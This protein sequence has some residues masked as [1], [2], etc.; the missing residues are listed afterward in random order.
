MSIFRCRYMIPRFNRALYIFSAVSCIKEQILGREGERFPLLSFSH[1]QLSTA[2][3]SSRSRSVLSKR[4]ILEFLRW[5]YGHVS[6]VNGNA[7][8]YAMST[9]VNAY[10]LSSVD[11]AVPVN[12]VYFR[13]R[14]AYWEVQKLVRAQ[15]CVSM[16]VCDW[17]IVR[18]W[19]HY[20]PQPLGIKAAPTLRT[21]SGF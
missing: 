3:A 15:S 4:L 11:F 13:P 21:P 5:R 2:R 18:V 14:R 10:R 9:S 7:Y 16:G 12:T 20:C 8:D 1:L 6:L 17:S 19:L